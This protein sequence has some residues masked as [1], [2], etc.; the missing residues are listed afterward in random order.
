MMPNAPK[1]TRTQRWLDLIAYLVGRRM[2]VAVSELME[3]L[4][5]YAAMEPKSARRVF[6]RDKQELREAGVPLEQI[7]YSINHGAEQADGYRLRS[8][9]FF[10]PYLALVEGRAEPAERAGTTRPGTVELAPE[11]A[12]AVFEAL[13]AAAPLPGLPLAADANRA[14]AKLALGV[15]ASVVRQA[16]VLYA[17]GSE[18]E[19]AGDALPALL[20]AVLARRCMRFSY[21][22]ARRGQATER[23]VRPYGLLMAGGGWYLIAHDEARGA[24]REFRVSRIAALEP[25][26]G[27]GA[28]EVPPDFQLQT[29]RHRQA[30]ELGDEPALGAEVRFRFPLSLWAERNGYGRA[31]REEA[32]GSVVRR[33]EVRQA[34]PFL[35]WLLTHLGEA[36][37]LAPSELIRQYD[38]L[39]HTVAA[40]Y[41]DP[42]EPSA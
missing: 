12:R 22:G 6:E 25:T 20:D 14:L 1:I 33:F 17:A 30:W 19:R 10:L 16:P 15:D 24:I 41:T 5:A 42:D 3:R 28:Y 40:L 26:G 29:Y 32:D 13:S 37:P 38:T 9:D 7:S 21:Q 39:V 11:D 36:E 27:P 23:V 8:G 35:R 4:P 18:S 34:E 31:L 2:P